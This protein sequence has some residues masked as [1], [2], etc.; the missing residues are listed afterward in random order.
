MADPATGETSTHLDQA[1]T[2]IDWLEA[3]DRKSQGNLAPE[4]ESVLRQ[5]LTT[6]R[7]NFV[8]EQKKAAEGGSDT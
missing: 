5:I 2:A 1:R 4:E 6:L 8:E 7:L 3:I